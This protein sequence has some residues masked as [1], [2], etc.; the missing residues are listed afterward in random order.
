MSTN[1]IETLGKL[2]MKAISPLFFLSTVHLHQHIPE[3]VECFFY[4]KL[5]MQVSFLSFVELLCLVAFEL[6]FEN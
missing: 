3:V 1:N 2:I 6:G 5:L 4:L